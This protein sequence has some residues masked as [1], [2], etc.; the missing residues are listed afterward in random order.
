MPKILHETD[1]VGLE[2]SM[3][4]VRTQIPLVRGVLRIVASGWESAGNNLAATA[5]FARF[6]YIEQS[7]Q[8]P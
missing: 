1:P 6:G 8:G 7:L 5:Y 2:A 4:R 3:R